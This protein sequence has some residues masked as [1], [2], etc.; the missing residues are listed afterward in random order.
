MKWRKYGLFKFR[1]SPMMKTIVQILVN[2][3][4]IRKERDKNISEI[5]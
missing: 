3:S 5:I 1:N 4:S 2:E